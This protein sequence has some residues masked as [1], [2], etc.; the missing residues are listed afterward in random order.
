MRPTRNADRE[1]ERVVI[2]AASFMRFMRWQPVFVSTVRE[3]INAPLCMY[4]KL[5]CLH[6]FS[7]DE[8][9]QTLGAGVSCKVASW[10][11]INA[12]R[13]ICRSCLAFAIYE[14]LQ[15]FFFTLYYGD[16][17]GVK[18]PGSSSLQVWHLP[19]K[20]LPFIQVFHSSRKI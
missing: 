13:M 18:E 4:A 17:G 16:L 20:Q 12:L 19:T 14:C 7:R 9:M 11:A 3:S 5:H 10:P 15:H 1:Y 6:V 2:F 8:G